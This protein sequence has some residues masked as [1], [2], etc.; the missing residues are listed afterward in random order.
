MNALVFTLPML[1]LV[2]KID[3]KVSDE[4][5]HPD[6]SLSFSCPLREFLLWY[7]SFFFDSYFLVVN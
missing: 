3:P 2:A 6:Y 5:D 4:T 7:L 1:H